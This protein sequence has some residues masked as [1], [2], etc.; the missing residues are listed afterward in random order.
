MVIYYY[1]LPHY[2]NR[3]IKSTHGIQQQ[4]YRRST[5]IQE[6]LITALDARG[7]TPF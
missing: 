3:I 6:E 2:E 4:D 1:W 7:A 5:Y